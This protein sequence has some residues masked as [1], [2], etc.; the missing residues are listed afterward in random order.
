MVE[1]QSRSTSVTLEWK[2]W[3]EKEWNA[4]R[5]AA[6]VYSNLHQV[7]IIPDRKSELYEKRFGGESSEGNETG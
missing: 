3:F 7:R 2:Q 4:V 1:S 5:R 6:S